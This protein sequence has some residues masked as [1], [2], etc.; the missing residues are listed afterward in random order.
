MI[1]YDTEHAAASSP[2]ALSSTAS[3]AGPILARPPRTLCKRLADE[4]RRAQL[5]AGGAFLSLRRPSSFDVRHILHGDNMRIGWT[6]HQIALADAG[7]YEC[8][9]AE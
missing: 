6:L 4:E 8:F 3:G 1:P 9:P 7:A 2:D 5:V